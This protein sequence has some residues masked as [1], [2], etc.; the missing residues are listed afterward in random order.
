MITKIIT[1]AATALAIS[2]AH[3]A[4]VDGAALAQIAKEQRPVAVAYVAGFVQG[5]KVHAAVEESIVQGRG[6]PME[7]WRKVMVDGRIMFCLPDEVS[8]PQAL[9]IVTKFIAENPQ[10]LTEPAMVVTWVA[11]VKS[12]PCKMPKNAAAL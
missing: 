2:S 12:H 5:W 1:A 11:L 8:P 10:Y 9:D 3:S 6:I 7:T 4:E